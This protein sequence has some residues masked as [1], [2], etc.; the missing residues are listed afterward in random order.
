MIRFTTLLATWPIAW[1]M[2]LFPLGAADIEAQSLAK[3]LP[4]AGDTMFDKLEAAQTGIDFVREWK[5]PAGWETEISGS[6]TGGG[7]AIGDFDGDGDADVFLSR[8][9]DGG[10]LYRNLGGFKFEDVTEE[11][12]VDSPGAWGA[13]CTWAD[14]DGDGWLDLYL[15]VFNAPNRLFINQ[16]GKGFV[17]KAQAFRLDFK[18]AS[19]MMAFS[20]YDRDGDLDGY[21]VTN[22]IK[23]GEE[24]KDVRFG[25]V[26]GPD[27]E[28]MVSPE[29]MQEYAGIIKS[30]TGYK[31]IA[32]GQ[33]DRLYRN[34]GAT[35]EGQIKFTEVGKES[36][37]R[38]SEYGLS[39][40]WWDYDGDRYPDLYVS[41]DF[42]GADHLY[43]NQRDGTFRDVAPQALPHT[44]WFSMGSDVADI[45]NDGLL[46]YMASDM[47]G[48]DHYKEKMSMG[49]M[50]GRDSD[51][52]FLNWPVPAQ[53]MRNAVY[54]NNGTGRFNEVAFLTGMAATDW[55]WSIK[56]G[57]LDCDGREDVFI[58]TG[59]S[60]DWF[61]SDMRNQEEAAIAKSGAAAGQA[62]WREKPPLALPNWAFRNDGDLKFSNVGKQWGLD[63]KSVSYG[64]AYGD[65]DGDGDLDLIVNDFDAAPRIYR[66]GCTEGN[67]V[68]LRLIGQKGDA[69][70]IGRDRHH[71]AENGAEDSQAHADTVA[72]V[73][74]LQRAAVA[75]WTRRSRE[76][77]AGVDRL[78]KWRAPGDEAPPG[79]QPLHDRPADPL[80]PDHAKDRDRA[81]VRGVGQT[82]RGHADR[83]RVRRLRTPTTAPREAFANGTRNRDR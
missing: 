74:V 3:A 13:G 4:P 8:M 58:T 78:A 45:N 50:T 38:G 39:A 26:N 52:W 69:W 14:V 24:L 12:G 6:F 73:H 51:T 72:R 76:S 46:D 21:L 44:P 66:N 40:T 56:F 15:C 49:N 35:P 81:M 34:D 9:T 20:D 47:A 32:S 23:P 48:S 75:L 71:R 19:L 80:P 29:F 65:L 18:G 67:R 1:A 25:L 54:L 10:R 42:Y 30:R 60:R 33:F 62:Y 22:R 68:S 59:M 36:G 37:I 53:Y 43:H 82:P 2:C 16:S 11:L 27:G 41:N 61:N 17:E 7:V 70:G 5:P 83:S 77:G 63:E 57:D 79:R 64:A 55:T 28:P 31:K